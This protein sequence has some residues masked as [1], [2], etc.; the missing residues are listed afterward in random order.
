MFINFVAVMGKLP[1]YICRYYAQFY[2]SRLFL[3]LFLLYDYITIFKGRVPFCESYI[4]YCPSDYEFWKEKEVQAVVKPM[5]PVVELLQKELGETVPPMTNNFFVWLCYFFPHQRTLATEHKLSFEDPSR[6]VT[7]T[8]EDVQPA[9]DLF[10]QNLQADTS[11][12]NLVSGWNDPDSNLSSLI[13]QI[14]A[15]L[16]QRS[17]TEFFEK[18]QRDTNVFYE[19]A[20]DLKQKLLPKPLVQDL[21][22]QTELVSSDYDPGSIA[23]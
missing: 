16:I 9:M 21:L 18:L 22:L 20:S 7:P 5:K 8:P 15:V 11:L 19:I 3:M 6:N 17:E 2:V 4:R 23:D 10:H 14:M 13:A 12:K 1:F